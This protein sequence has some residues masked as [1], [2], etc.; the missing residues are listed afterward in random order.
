MVQR[1]YKDKTFRHSIFQERLS[2]GG[3]I[4]EKI[5]VFYTDSKPVV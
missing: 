2:G 5:I 4:N 1:I 3:E